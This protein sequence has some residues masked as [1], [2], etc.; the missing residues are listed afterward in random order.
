M[1]TQRPGVLV[2]VHCRRLHALQPSSP[3]VTELSGQLMIVIVTVIASAAC[4]SGPLTLLF[5]ARV[6]MSDV[7]VN[8]RVVG[9]NS[10]V[11]H[12]RTEKFQRGSDS[13]TTH[14]HH[15]NELNTSYHSYSNSERRQHHF[16][17]TPRLNH[18]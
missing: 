10:I 8:V 3:P 9:K 5:G 6:I 16:N 17:A 14:S 2:G 11:S 4:D 12:V 7:V 15:G 18:D 13:N 1:A